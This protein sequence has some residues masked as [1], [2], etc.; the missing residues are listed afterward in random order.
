MVYSWLSESLETQSLHAQTPY[1]PMYDQDLIRDEVRY[2][3]F[4]QYFILQNN[5]LMFSKPK[6]FY[7]VLWCVEIRCQ[8]STSFFLPTLCLFSPTM[9]V[10]LFC[11][12]L[13]CFVMV[14]VVAISEKVLADYSFFLCL[15]HSVRSALP[16]LGDLSF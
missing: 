13:F 4:S 14:I 12:V 7:I 11:F 1:L 5:L 9:F 8:H 3:I 6:S 16:W 15:V 10:V 2:H